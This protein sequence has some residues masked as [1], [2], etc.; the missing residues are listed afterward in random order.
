MNN[1]S[2]G[3]RTYFVGQILQALVA[4][5]TMPIDGCEGRAALADE[6]VLLADAVIDRMSHEP[7]KK[8]RHGLP[9]EEEKV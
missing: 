5:A 8:F 9:V 4:R 7:E 6:A 3:P 1:P 2:F